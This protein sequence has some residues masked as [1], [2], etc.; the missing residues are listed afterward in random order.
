MLERPRS[1]FRSRTLPD[2]RAL[3][4]RNARVSR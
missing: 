2:T 4:A 3:E 1:H